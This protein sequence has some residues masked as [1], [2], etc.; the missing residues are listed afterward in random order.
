MLFTQI[1][2]GIPSIKVIANKI[3]IQDIIPVFF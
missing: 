3:E 2:K 1:C